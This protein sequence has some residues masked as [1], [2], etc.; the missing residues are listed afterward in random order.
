[1][2]MNK[3]RSIMMIAALAMAGNVFGQDPSTHLA[4]DN[5]SNYDESTPWGS[6]SNKGFGFGEWAITTGAGSSGVFV[7][8]P[9]S[10]GISGMS[11]SS[12]A[13]YAN[14]DDGS[15]VNAER[16]INSGLGIGDLFSFDWGINWDS[17]GGNKGINLYVGGISGTQVININ[18]GNQPITINGDTM[19]AEY[20]TSVMTINVE[21]TSSTGLRVFATGRNGS[22]SYDNTFTLV[23]SSIDAFRFYA[24]N[25]PSGENSGN[26]QPYF[27]NLAVIPEPSSIIMMG[28]T[29]LAA[30]GL[31]LLKRHRKA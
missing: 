5:A 13:L 4:F 11:T 26:H 24:S 6:E 16:S 31:T 2:K 27:N 20:G 7:G 21:R 8:D 28:L 18:N 10:G 25:L 19:F 12:F 1:M 22:E 30:A 23:D 3:I 29:G 17:S 14:N 15:F 9:S